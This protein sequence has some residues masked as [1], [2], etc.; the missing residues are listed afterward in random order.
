MIVETLICIDIHFKLLERRI[1][2]I[3][4]C[5]KQKSYIVKKVLN[6]PFNCDDVYEQLYKHINTDTYCLSDNFHKITLP[7]HIVP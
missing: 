1:N 3:G 6:S 5:S 4:K 7:N 2:N